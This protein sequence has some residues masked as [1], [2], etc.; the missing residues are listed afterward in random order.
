GA[1]LVQPAGLM[2]IRGPQENV[3]AADVFILSRRMDAREHLIDLVADS[4]KRLPRSVFQRSVLNE[5]VQDL[6]SLKQRLLLVAIFPK[7][8]LPL[9][10]LFRQ[11][12][13]LGRA[14]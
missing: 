3:G 2:S 14:F 1:D 9:L 4:V 13:L 6:A 11:V 12:P 5:V 7:A 8:E 10:N